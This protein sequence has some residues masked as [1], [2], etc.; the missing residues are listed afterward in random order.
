MASFK[1]FWKTLKEKTFG[2]GCHLLKIRN[3]KSEITER[4]FDKQSNKPFV[5]KYF[6]FT[7][8]FLSAVDVSKEQIKVTEESLLVPVYRPK[9]ARSHF[10]CVH[11][12]HRYYGHVS[13][14]A[15]GFKHQVQ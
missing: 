14:I 15:A 8:I 9:E 6:C 5:T 11:G 10:F 4:L 7:L 2:C 3:P 1:L 12:S 13:P